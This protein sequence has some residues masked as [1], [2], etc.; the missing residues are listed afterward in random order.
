MWA[1]R[2]EK[3]TALVLLGDDD[4]PAALKR[5]MPREE[6]VEGS[7]V[8]FEGSKINH[9]VTQVTAGTRYAGEVVCWRARAPGV[10]GQQRILALKCC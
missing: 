1:G 9:M 10:Q 7:M 6:Q 8:V 3:A 4:T 2:A 5:V